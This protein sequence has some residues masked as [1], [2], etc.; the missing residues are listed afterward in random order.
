MDRAAT[1]TQIADALYHARSDIGLA[2]ALYEHAIE[3][4][5]DPLTV[6]HNQWMCAM[7][8]GDFASAW[9]VSDRVMDERKKQQMSCDGLPYHL[10]WV[11]DGTS[12]GGR[13][14]L[15]RCFHGV[16]DAIQFIR[17]ID[18]LRCVARSVTVQAVPE[19]LPLVMRT[20]GVGA[21]VSLEM[22]APDPP[23]D[24]DIELMEVPHA[25]RLA[26]DDVRRPAPY[27]RMDGIECDVV[28]GK[29][30]RP[31]GFLVGIAWAAGSW[32]PERSLRLANLRP[33]FAIPGITAVNLQR[34]PALAELNEPTVA[35]LP[36]IES[37]VQTTDLIETGAILLGLDAVISVDTM[38][39]HLAGALG[40]PVC[41]LLDYHADWRWMLVRSDTPWYPTMRL[42][43][44]PSPG[45]WDAVIG[46][47]VM[48]LSAM[49]R[50]STNC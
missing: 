38:V 16:G 22:G 43:R 28:G 35:T 49:L 24:V 11:W 45:D 3:L 19:V 5:A 31:A 4:G 26:V 10:R 40:V 2:L 7:L 42:I 47:A 9:S 13:H 6:A 20:A 50:S 32:R 33:I 36:F 37:G 29:F 34:G 39:A 18:S 30:R 21:A 17:F 46:E 14:V 27:I 23:Y 15:V 41:T 48:V 12:L 1:A 25:L 8:L 44:Q